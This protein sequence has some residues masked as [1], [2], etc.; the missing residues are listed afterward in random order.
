MSTCPSK[1]S[2]FQWRN[3][4][5]TPTPAQRQQRREQLDT[6][7]TKYEKYESYLIPESAFPKFQTCEIWSKGVLHSWSLTARPVKND[8]WKTT[9]LLGMVYFQGLLLLNFQGRNLT[10]GRYHFGCQTR[11]SKFAGLWQE[12]GVRHGAGSVG[13]FRTRGLSTE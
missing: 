13:H 11:H 8:G 4:I 2:C 1:S 7:K 10:L 6:P 12:T 9:F 5:D 3:Q